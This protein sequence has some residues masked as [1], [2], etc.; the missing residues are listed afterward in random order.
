[1]SLCLCP[2]FRRITFNFQNG[3]ENTILK[4]DT[5]KQIFVGFWGD[6]KKTKEKLKNLVGLQSCEQIQETIKAGN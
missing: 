4:L 2:P 3:Q 1:L 6:C 5:S